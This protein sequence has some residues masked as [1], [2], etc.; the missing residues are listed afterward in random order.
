[1]RLHVMI[2]T[3]S[4]RHF[5]FAVHDRVPAADRARLLDCILGWSH[6][7]AGRAVLA[8]GA[9]PGFVPAR[10]Q[11]YDPVRRYSTRLKSLA[12]Q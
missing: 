12:Q 10:D 2:E 1:M 11:D 9:W 6:G 5:V 3:A 8:A 4:I 7:E